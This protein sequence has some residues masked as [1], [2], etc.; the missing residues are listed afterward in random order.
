MVW[1]VITAPDAGLE[2]IVGAGEISALAVPQFE[3]KVAK[4][5]RAAR[6]TSISP[7]FLFPTV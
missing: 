3:P 6:S 4:T 2:L 5:A 1:P 7:N